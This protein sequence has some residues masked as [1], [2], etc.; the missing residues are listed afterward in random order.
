M[1]SE[2]EAQDKAEGGFSGNSG[3]SSGSNFGGNFS[4]AKDFAFNFQNLGYPRHETYEQADRYDQTAVRAV[5][6]NGLLTV[7]IPPR[8]EDMSGAIKVEILKKGN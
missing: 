6:R 3:G 2:A 4:G 8:E 7:T 1:A 5:F